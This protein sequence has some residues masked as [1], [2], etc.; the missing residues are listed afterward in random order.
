MLL[1]LSEDVQR[2]I[3]ELLS[4]V[5][6]PATVICLSRCCRSLHAATRAP[7]VTLLTRHSA[8]KQLCTKVRSSCEEASEAQGLN[9][10]HE[11]L[12]AADVATL[13]MLVRTNA[14]PRLEALS[15]DHNGFGAEAMQALCE[16]LGHGTLRRLQYLVLST[17]ALGSEGAA[18]LAAALG[19]GALPQLKSLG[20][21]G[22]HIGSYGLI[23][24]A[25]PLR[26]LQLL[27]TLRLWDNEIGDEGVV[28]LL[29]N[30]DEKHKQL[31][32][33]QEIDLEGNRITATGCGTLIAA[34]DGGAL[35]KLR[36]LDV[37]GNP[38]SEMA[39]EAVL[40]AFDRNM[41]IKHNINNQ[42]SRPLAVGM[43]G[44]GVVL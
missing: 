13:E 35:P 44:S 21:G 17:N 29:A 7:L 26:Q 5:L 30:L 32:Q 36:V 22:N 19:R 6:R 10:Y 33:L 11:G 43:F 16:E 15:L 40:A 12:T 25:P 27:K 31:K 1:D 24:L 2:M 41:N 9:W 42:R 3:F 20:L 14:L 34:L 23:T 8:A 18:A 28:A 4:T 37:E 39:K 38:M